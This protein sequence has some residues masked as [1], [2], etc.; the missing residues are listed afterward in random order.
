MVYEKYFKCQG[1]KDYF[2]FRLK[3]DITSGLMK[4][5]PCDVVGMMGSGLG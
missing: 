2:Y 1:K 3:N 4:A 5:E